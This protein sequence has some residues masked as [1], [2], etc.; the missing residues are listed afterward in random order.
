MNKVKL[1]TITTFRCAVH[2]PTWM[3]STCAR[4]L[5]RIVLFLTLLAG[6]QCEN[7]TRVPRGIKELQA[8]LN[9]A[10]RP[11]P[12]FLGHCDFEEI[13]DWSWNR[14]SGFVRTSAPVP[15]KFGPTTDASKSPNGHF[16]WLYGRDGQIS[17]RQIP[18]TGT[19]CLL[20]VALHQVEMRNGDIRLIIQTNNFTSLVAT[21]RSG[22]NHAQ[23]EITRFNLGAMNQPYNVSLEMVVPYANS[24]IAVDN[25]R[26]VDCFPESPPVGRVC[27]D[28]MFLCNNGSCL[29]RTRICDL[30]PDCADGEDELV[31]CDK[32]PEYSRCNFEDGWCG[33]TNVPGRPLNWTLHQGPTPT[34][35]TGPSYDHTYRNTTGTYAFVDMSR[36]AEYG[37]R[38]TIESPV[39][40]PTPPYNS[41]RTSPYYQS[42]QVRFFYHQYGVHQGSL[43]LYLVQIKPH[44]N[45]SERLWWNYGDRS[46]VWYNQAVILPDTRYRYFLQFEAS[47]GYASKS[48]IAIDDFSLSPE[49]F[50]IGVPADIVGD[51][52]YYNPIIELESK[53]EQHVDFANET[54][55]RITTCGALGRTGPTLEECNE[56]Y[57]STEIELLIPP[58]SS[59]S[60]SDEATPFNFKGIQR[61]TAPR[62]GYYTVIAMGARGGRGSG[63]MG[64]TLGALVQGIIELEKGQ[65][66][67]FMV[68]QPGSDAC[69]KNLGLKTHYCQSSTQTKVSS[70]SGTSSIVRE[71]KNI[72]LKDGGGGGGGATYIF[73]LKANGEQQPLLIAAGGGGLGLGHFVNDGTQHGQGPPPPGRNPTSGYT[74]KGNA[75]AGG[76]WN[77]SSNNMTG[78]PSMGMPLIYGGIGGVGCGNK[79]EGHGDGGFGGGGGGCLTGGGGGGYI[80]GS[81]G[82][83]ES[84]NGE[85]GYSYAS[86]ELLHISF[87]PG[88]NQGPGEVFI[89]A[90]ISGCGCDF[91]CVVTDQHLSQTKCLCPPGW[92]LGNNSHSCLMTD[93]PTVS[94]RTFMMILVAVSLVLLF[95]FSGLCALLYNRYQNRKALSRRRQVMFGNGTELTALRAVSDNMMTEFNP[96]YEFAGN[97]YTFKDLPQIPRDNISLVKP[98]GQGAFGEVFQGVYKY[99]C[100]EEHPVA[101]KTLP[102]L[103]TSQAEADFMMEA[104]IMSKFNH[105]NIVHFIGVSFDKHPR[106]IVLELL[107]GG[108]L[109]NF[110]REERPRP[111]RSTKLTM[112]DLVMCAFDVANGCKYMEDARFI[113]RDIAAR[114]CLLTCKGPGRVVKIADFG[115]ARDIYRSD[116]YRKGGK[117][118]LPIKWMPPESFLDGI[119]TTK[120]D[121]W[122]FGVLLWE[123]MSFGYMPYTGCANRE[124]MSMVTNGG[125]LERPAGCPDPIYGVMTRCWHPHPEDRPSFT[126]IVERIGYCLQDP[127]VINYPMPNYDIL[128]VYEREVTIMRPDPETECINVRSNLDGCGYMQ[129]RSN[130]RAVAY[131]IGP[132]P[133]I[134]YAALRHCDDCENENIQE[135]TLTEPKNE[136]N[137]CLNSP[138]ALEDPNGDYSNEE[139]YQPE[140]KHLEQN[141]N[142]ASSI[143]VANDTENNYGN[144]TNNEK[145]KQNG[146]GE[147]TTT[148]DTNSPPDTL[149][150]LPNTRTSSPSHTVLNANV[151]INGIL[152]KSALK[153][154]LSLDPSALCRGTI[155]YEKIAFSPPPPRLSNPGSM[156][157]RKGSLG[158]ELPREEECSC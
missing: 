48:D 112:Q 45:Q 150:S 50:G 35:R 63:G 126:T 157:L 15:S 36:R 87:K 127:D 40:N 73:T 94:H 74:V 9:V 98:L 83:T 131:R 59:V 24:S 47:K 104:L 42:C 107:A 14:T 105:G 91:R 4:K 139:K 120:T 81:T 153:A 143:G 62:G 145:G 38:A 77:G 92:L 17:S 27:T 23:W 119:F 121:V 134:V 151:N 68:G 54:V 90:A 26:L 49:C 95:A 3:I 80:G 136:G 29:N 5:F 70:S 31:E 152:R 1:S 76:G 22:N 34:E 7:G 99:R 130:F 75:G 21:E 61:W 89:I 140:V 123:I 37:S 155:P 56:E 2:R 86:S 129:P 32:M 11:P 16:L 55:V 97:L 133:G 141:T 39:F 30:T 149:V 13:C 60:A 85:G 72:K 135:T 154:A 53:P 71:V 113:H 118:M 147:S 69:P 116:Y 101:V 146:N 88:V 10:A 138:D 82:H 52:N 103:S 65:Q 110:L 44:Q 19:R 6:I 79:I 137:D 132:A 28:D 102:S 111:D 96:N 156:E 18:R 33:W 84:G 58:L 20:E 100:N 144:V 67:Y 12:P 46:D 8:A 41:D 78:Q 122:A 109:K 115:M 51:F 117:A 142:N 128:P 125:R 57:N 25:I 64:S 106:Y 114:N 124:V 158:H 108:D 148:T 43:G 93:K 66:I